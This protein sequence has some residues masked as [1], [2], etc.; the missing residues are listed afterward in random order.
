MAAVT[1]SNDF[2]APQKIK[3][4]TVSTVSPSICHK[5]M[6]PDAVI[7]IFWMKDR[8]CETRLVWWFV[9]GQQ[10]PLCTW[11]KQFS[12][13]NP[14]LW[15]RGSED[16]SLGVRAKDPVSLWLSCNLK[17][18]NKPC[19]LPTSTTLQQLRPGHDFQEFALLEAYAL[20]DINYEWWMIRSSLLIGE[21]HWDGGQ[22]WSQ[23]HDLLLHWNTQAPL[24][25]TAES[26]TGALLPQRF[27]HHSSLVCRGESG[28]NP[29]GEPG[30]L[31][32][33][34]PQ[35][36]FTY[37]SFTRNMW[38]LVNVKGNLLQ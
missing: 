8:Y 37:L 7:F 23:S 9:L 36:P 19:L 12:D 20:V 4:A 38:M 35:S 16:T 24:G 22:G 15:V 27:P 6:G 28:H 17:S 26:A 31:W 3:S 33:V 29:R 10:D 21:A 18:E 5:V 11:G 1:I 13:S 25:G 2:G 32:M 34:W 14:L 30:M